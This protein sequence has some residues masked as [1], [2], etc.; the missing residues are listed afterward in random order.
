LTWN[1]FLSSLFFPVQRRE[2]PIDWLSIGVAILLFRVYLAYTR[3]ASVELRAGI[4]CF[5]TEERTV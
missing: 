4:T 1:L 5:S 3:R 2:L